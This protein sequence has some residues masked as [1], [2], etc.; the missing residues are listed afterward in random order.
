MLGWDVFVHRRRATDPADGLLIG[1]WTTG[2]F[3]LKWLDDLV[4]TQEALDLG[5]NGGYPCRYSMRAATFRSAIAKEAPPTEPRPLLPF[6]VLPPGWISPG[7]DRAALSGCVP[8]DELVIEA[9]DQS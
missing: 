9:W 3:G 7:V 2:V 5:R 8:D 1:R 6:E 4:A